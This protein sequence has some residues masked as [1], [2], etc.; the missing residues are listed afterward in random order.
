MTMHREPPS[1][2][3]EPDDPGPAREQGPPTT[4]EPDFPPSWDI[5]EGVVPT[6]KDLD[7]LV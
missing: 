1:Q 7:R 4:A 3:G 2:S 6:I 5:R